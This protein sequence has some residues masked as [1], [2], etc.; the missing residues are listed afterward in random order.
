MKGRDVSVGIA[1][2]GFR[3]GRA[4]GRIV[5]MPMRAFAQVWPARSVVE[6]SSERLAR[7]GAAARTVAITRVESAAS[8][9]LTGPELERAID[10]VLAAPL[11]DAVARKLIDHVL[12][13]PEIDRVVEHVASSPAVRAA[14]VHQSTGL[15]DEVGADLRARGAAHD[16]SIEARARKLFHRP[17]RSGAVV[18]GGVATRTIAFVIDLVVLAT[19]FLGVAALVALGASLI[20]HIGGWPLAALLTVSWTLAGAAYFILFWSTAGQTPG[21]RAMRLRVVRANGEPCGVVRCAVRYL[22]FTLGFLVLLAGLLVML[23]DDRRRTLHDLVA[24][25]VVVQVPPG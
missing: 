21:L 22:V 19:A 9:A 23:V 14:V 1:V 20:G 3:T 18:Y 8:A 16:G 13:S 17:A 15:V 4:A 6:L 7:G 11:S 24:G 5:A 2:V 12:A 25:T 10:R